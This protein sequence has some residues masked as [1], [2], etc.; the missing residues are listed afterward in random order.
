M[1]QIGKVNLLNAQG[2]KD[3]AKQVEKLNL[4]KVKGLEKKVNIF[5]K[6]RVK[7]NNEN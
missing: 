2:E 4:I 5:L 6:K 7:R 3:L 1:S